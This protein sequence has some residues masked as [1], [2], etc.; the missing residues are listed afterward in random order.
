MKSSILTA[1]YLWKD[2]WSGW[3][4]RPGSF[5]SK[6]LV[7]LI[8]GGLAAVLLIAF[9][10]QAKDLQQRMDRF[11][12]NSIVISET[13]SPQH[14]RY[15]QPVAIDP[16]LDSLQNKG[17]LYVFHQRLNPIVGPSM[18]RLS[19][20]ILP[21][22]IFFQQ[23]AWDLPSDTFPALL[24]S[25]R[26]PEGSY[27][28][29]V[30]DGM[31]VTARTLHSLPLLQS[32]P[33]GDK[34]ILPDG[35]L[36][37]K[38][39]HVYQEY[40]V[41]R[42]HESHSL[43]TQDQVQWLTAL[44]QTEQRHHVLLNSAIDLQLQLEELQQIQIIWKAFLALLVGVVLALILGS[45]S[46]LEYQQNQYVNA[47]LR[48]FGAT[49]EA[50]FLRFL[51]E[52]LLIVNGA[53]LSGIALVRVLHSTVFGTLQF[54]PSILFADITS[55]YFSP[56][57]LVLFLWANGGAFLSVVPIGWMLRKPVGYVLS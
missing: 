27:I 6:A 55:A 9:H 35:A 39:G 30:I 51:V 18:E 23:F 40:H 31:E 11:G 25:Q 50:I 12:V 3:F 47:L 53:L 20:W 52:A 45:L 32:L 57:I 34:L 5:L 42:M 14:P 36:P 24:V 49:S 41:Y 21:E 56:E 15:H 2:I 28:P 1:S 48:S 22:T 33:D 54:P 4:E 29:F 37:N 7:S 13:I 44:Y 17:S 10:L 38:N 8:L 26:Y 46:F 19:L 43:H 16:L